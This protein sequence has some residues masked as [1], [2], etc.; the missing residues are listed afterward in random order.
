MARCRVGL[1]RHDWKGVERADGNGCTIPCGAKGV[2]GAGAG[3][4]VAC[5]SDGAYDGSV[6][7]DNIVEALKA[8]RKKSSFGHTACAAAL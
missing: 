6:L 4:G 8:R 7:A 2:R 1:R 5:L 3:C